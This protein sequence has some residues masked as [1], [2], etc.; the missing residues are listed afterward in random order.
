MLPCPAVWR[1]VFDPG[2]NPNQ[3]GQGRNYYD[4]VKVSFV[5]MPGG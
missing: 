4:N 2:S 1:S 3:V 5:A